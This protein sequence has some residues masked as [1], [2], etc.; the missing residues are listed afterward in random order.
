ML[1]SKLPMA[2]LAAAIAAVIHPQAQAQSAASSAADSVLPVIVVTADP[3]GGRTPDDL[4]QPISVLSGAALER[5]REATL[6][7]LLDGLP[8]VS[9]SDFGPG[10]GRPTVRG[11]QGSRV[12]VLEDGM[13][14]ADVSGEGADHAIAV[15]P[16]R[17]DQIEVFRGPS[18][19]AYGSGAAGG[20]VNVRSWR[21]NPEFGDRPSV[22]G[23]LRYGENGN[24]RQGYVGFELPGSDELV[25]RAD[26]SLRR[27][28]DF[29]ISGFQ[30]VD[31][32][33]G[34]RGKLVNSS[35]DTD[36]YSLTGLLRQ[37]WGFVG[38]GVSRWDTEYGIPENFD[39][40]P[41]DLG[42]QA[43]EF[44]RIFADYDRFDLRGEF[45]QPFAG[46]EMARVKFSYTEFEMEEVEF[47][48]DRTPEGGELDETIVEA[49]F[50]NDELDFRLE[51]VHAPIGD[52]RGVFGFQF[53]ERDFDAD[54]PRG[55]DRT[56]YVRPTT[57]RTAAL[58]VIE[59]RPMDFGRIELGA[60]IERERASPDDVV[61]SRVPGVTLTG[62]EFLALPEA[63]GNRTFTPFSLSA[64]AIVELDPDHHLRASITRAERAPSPEQLYA[65][66]R[67]S[68]AGTFEVGDV[69]LGK[70]SYVNLELG[71]DR[72]TG[73]IRFDLSIFYNRVNDFIFLRSEDDG[74]GSPVGVNDIGNRA[75]EG[76]TI[77][78]EPGDG[79]LCRLRNQ[80]VFNEQAN[81]EFWGGEIG[82]VTDLVTGV[83]P[84]SLRFSADSVR[85][86]LR[87][88]G[89]L[90]RI[91]PPR[92]GLGID[93]RFGEIDV[94]AD[95]RRVFK[96]SR[97]GDAEDRTSGYNLLSFDVTWSPAAFAGTE[98][99]LRGRNLLNEDGRQHQSFFKEEAPIIGRAFIGGVR[100]NF[101]G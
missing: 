62:G 87:S 20:V 67:H 51:L 24:D 14:V 47:E 1:S 42:G 89:N 70:E 39:A 4:I 82:A 21:F 95:F 5:R 40:R 6:G 72:H 2:T 37:D 76:A 3:I 74:T 91:T 9:N 10:V 12:K 100:F 90:P 64:G 78:C 17:A 31:Q 8:G 41:R 23:E 83:N 34:R 98:V 45:R 55:G 27:T 26:A 57:T 101:G 58:F 33:A 35:L 61:G 79:G 63:P 43:D 7:A 59:E 30:Q 19:L 81:A 94:S 68:A 86:K 46:I 56:F 54:D 96:Q 36:S 13:G 29:D 84:V 99:F 50:E 80:L 92:V 25:F 48:F 97:T 88:G 77:G 28:S 18:T 73:P 32:T 66:G 44:E 52:W 69:T 15:D 53:T 22:R 93:A 11:L 49:V 38:I 71:V 75:G 60:R 16:A 65:F 85:G